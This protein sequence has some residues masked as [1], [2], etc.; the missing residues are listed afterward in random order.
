MTYGV[1][2][3]V[4]DQLA[5]FLCS[6]EDRFSAGPFAL[7]SEDYPL[8]TFARGV[9]I[10]CL[11]G[12]LHAPHSMSMRAHEMLWRHSS[13]PPRSRRRE[14]SPGLVL[15]R[16]VDIGFRENVFS[17][18]CEQTVPQF[19]GA[20]ARATTTAMISTDNNDWIIVRTLA[21]LLRTAVSV[22]PKVRLVVKA[23]NK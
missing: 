23:R 1:W 7:H 5:S 3:P 14:P 9:D 2:G 6:N 12:L 15:C 17:A 19:H 4:L 20:V 21:R 11:R 22:G 10:A 16:I 18:V 8:H 13:W